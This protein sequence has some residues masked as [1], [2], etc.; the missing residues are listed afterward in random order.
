M[1]KIKKVNLTIAEITGVIRGQNYLQCVCK[2][3]A[4]IS[5]I[6]VEDYA[7]LF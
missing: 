1:I 2:L 3:I 4:A 7:K 5:L 6:I